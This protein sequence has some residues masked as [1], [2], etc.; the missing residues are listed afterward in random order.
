LTYLISTTKREAPKQAG[1]T[2]VI[3]LLCI[4]SVLFWAFYF[5]MFMSLILF[6]ARVVQPD[7]FGI[8]F[9]PPYYVGVQSV[10]MLFFGFFLSRRKTPMTC[11]QSGISS[12]NKFMLAML[13][14]VAAYAL[15]TLICKTTHSLTLLSPLLFI[16][17]YLFISIAELL[18][19]PVGLS[20]ITT[21]ASRRKV[22]TMMGIFFVSLGIGGFLSGKL[23]TLTAINPSNLT[24]P[25]LKWHY[26]ETFSHLL[27]ILMIATLISFFLNKLI[28]KLLTRA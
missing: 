13:F 20:A 26:G 6:L 23:A 21:L 2:M 1:Q 19:S 12:G 22:S 18:L 17:A 11:V 9:P 24:M 4:I 28:K 7:L 14:M 16:P 27:I 8:P 25:E 3:G 10:G 15:I 5:Q